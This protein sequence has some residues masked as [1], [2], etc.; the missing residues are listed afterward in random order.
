KTIDALLDVILS[1]FKPTDSSVS[2]V[3]LFDLSREET[4]RVS[5]IISFVDGFDVENMVRT[6]KIKK[7]AVEKT[8]EINRML[9]NAMT[10]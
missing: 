7:D 6:V 10:A 9:K 1:Q 4:G 5:A 8:T 3:P 2:T